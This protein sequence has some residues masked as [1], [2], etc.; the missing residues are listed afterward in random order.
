MG[1]ETP[2]LRLEE[3]VLPKD[4]LRVKT[5]PKSLLC[6]LPLLKVMLNDKKI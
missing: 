1:G 4:Q 2:A 3:G 6:G 5:F